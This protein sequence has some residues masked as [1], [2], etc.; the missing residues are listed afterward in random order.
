MLAG[1]RSGSNSTLKELFLK[2]KHDWT[3]FVFIAMYNTL[4]TFLVLYWTFS[5]SVPLCS[6][7]ARPTS[8]YPNVNP[9]L[10]FGC[11]LTSTCERVP[12]TVFKRFGCVS[13]ILDPGLNVSIRLINHKIDTFVSST[14]EMHSS[15]GDIAI[16]V[17][18]F[19]K[20]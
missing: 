3:H 7:N 18:A 2:M 4:V 13:T 5:V 11:F 19:I 17:V 12:T 8:R 6:R 10:S 14:L 16:S 9:K 20:L 15:I 1:T